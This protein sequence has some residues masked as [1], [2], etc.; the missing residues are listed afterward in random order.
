MDC[1]R[2][3]CSRFNLSLNISLLNPN[4]ENKDKNDIK[5]EIK[6]ATL[7]TLM[8]DISLQVYE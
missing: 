2:N 6:V 8:L 5:T 1:D 4:S 7:E 3:R